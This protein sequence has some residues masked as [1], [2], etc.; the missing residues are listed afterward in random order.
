[1]FHS[2][3]T[4]T[5]QIAGHLNANEGLTRNFY[6]AEAIRIE[7]AETVVA[8]DIV[9]VARFCGRCGDHRWL[10]SFATLSEAQSGN[11]PYGPVYRFHIRSII[12]DMRL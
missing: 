12:T 7:T 8:P 1:L 5:T 11:N 2:A 6:F 4:A 9:Q 3:S 10:S